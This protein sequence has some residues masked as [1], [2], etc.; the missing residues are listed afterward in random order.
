MVSGYLAFLLASE[1]SGRLIV[2]HECEN[3][4]FNLGYLKLGIFLDDLII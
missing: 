1:R 3:G 2:V 4:S